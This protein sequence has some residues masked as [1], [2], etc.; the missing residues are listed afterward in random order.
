MSLS[1]I[2]SYT[3]LM[4]KRLNKDVP[5]VLWVH[6]TLKL[7]F[8]SLSYSQHLAFNLTM[9]ILLLDLWCVAWMIQLSFFVICK[10]FGNS[11]IA[12]PMQL[13]VPLIRIL[14]RK[15]DGLNRFLYKTKTLPPST[16][17]LTKWYLVGV[18]TAFT[19]L[20]CLRGEKCTWLPFTDMISK[21]LKR[22]VF[23]V[24]NITCDKLK[25]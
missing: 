20:H 13:Q 6:G 1:C 9:L 5:E 22:S 16:L 24:F 8:H 21:T 11:F 4:P 18:Q 25:C 2:F 19:G 12:R 7:S 17:H 23:H 3:W 14:T 10:M 15:S